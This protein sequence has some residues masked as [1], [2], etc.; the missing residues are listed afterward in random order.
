MWSTTWRSQGT[1]SAAGVDQILTRRSRR[2]QSQETASLRGRA[3]V[4]LKK[5]AKRA[6]TESKVE[7]GSVVRVRVPV[8]RSLRVGYSRV[9]RVRAGKGSAAP[10]ARSPAVAMVAGVRDKPLGIRAAAV[11]VT[12][13]A[14][15]PSP[16]Q[17][18]RQAMMPCL[19]TGPSLI[20][21]Q[22]LCSSS[23]ALHF[24]YHLRIKKKRQY[25]SS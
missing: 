24:L 13:L 22:V 3:V 25:L 20:N 18:R 8:G 23:E 11:R 7:R 14:A 19:G 17:R 15:L 10:G 21:L 2:R 4:R 16:H 9:H 12:S 1:G 5:V 6:S